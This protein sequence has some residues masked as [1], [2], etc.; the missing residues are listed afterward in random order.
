MIPFNRPRRP[1]T[2]YPGLGVTENEY[3][4]A[5][6]LISDMSVESRAFPRR[7][8]GMKD[9]AHPVPGGDA[10]TTHHPTH[11]AYYS[12]DHHNRFQPQ[13]GEQFQPAQL[14]HAP[15]PNELNLAGKYY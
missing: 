6:S 3:M 7:H 4:T 2:Q 15:N 13:R 9:A 10:F 11:R 14:Y 8:D 12:G 1:I 5:P